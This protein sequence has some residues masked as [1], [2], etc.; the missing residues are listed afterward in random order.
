MTRR[1]ALP[2]GTDEALQK[3][4]IHMRR[5]Y[6]ANL[7][8]LPGLAF[9]VLAVIYLR[10]RHSA[11]TLASAHLAQTFYASLWA[12]ALL[13]IVNLS[14]IGLG[15]Y[16]GHITWTLVIVYFTICHSFLV[17]LGILAKAMAGQCWLFPL[18]GRPLP[19][20]CSQYE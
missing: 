11:P 13:M 16:S 9:I 4:K 19:E 2:W 3:P 15:G 7:L 18:V 1:D 17:I 8:L 10:K 14:I 6:T 5:V 12:G 20:D